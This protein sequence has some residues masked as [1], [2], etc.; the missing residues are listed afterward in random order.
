M[1]RIALGAAITAAALAT[2]VTSAAPQ[3]R[4]RD[5]ER[6]VTRS[7][8]G[9]AKLDDALRSRVDDGSTAQVYVFVTVSGSD[10]G[11]VRALLDDDAAAQRRGKA[12]VVGRISTQAV[13]KL[14]SLKNV[15]SVGLVQLTQT[16]KPLG[17]PDPLV[18]RQPS[19]ATGA[20][21]LKEL[22]AAE[23]PY[24]QAPAPK[25]SNFEQLRKLGVMDAKTH[26]FKDA[27]DAGYAGEG[28]TVGVLDGG[29]DFGHPDLLNTWQTWSGVTDTDFTDDGW[30]GWPKAFDPFG[31]LQ[32]LA[33]P[34]QVTGGLSW[35]TPTSAVTCP[36]GTGDCAVTFAT[37][38][39][40][41]RNFSAPNARATHTYTF[42]RAWSKSGRVRMGSH[43]D[44]YLLELYKERPAFLVT[45]P[46][47]AGVYDTV[48]VDLDH[49]NDFGDEKPVTKQSPA[50]YRDVNGDGY[51]DLS[52][53]LLYF[54]SDG[55]TRLP[56]GLAEFFGP[57]TPVFAPGAMLAWS[58]DYDPG[59]EGH[60]T[61]T[62]SNV[63]GQ[64][65]IN[66]GAPQFKDLPKDGRVPGAVLGGSPHA[67][68][69]P[70]GDIYFGF[71]FSTQFGYLLSTLHGID[72]TSNSYGSSDVDNDGYDAA[73]QEAD[74]IHDGS[75]TTPLF[76]TGNG[77][78]GFGTATSPQPSAG[79]AVG[80]STQFGATG[81]DSLAK[82]REAPDNDVISFS[83]RGP[84]ATGS[85][86]P[87]L[88]ADGAYSSG[89]ATLNTV[90]DGR[91]AW[92]TWGGT[93]RSTPVAVS[94]TALVYQAYKK[95]HGGSV[96]AGFYDTA[97]NILKSSA[98]DLHYDAFTQGAGSLDAGRAVRA[99]AG[100]DTTV[101]PDEW[102][103]G[104]YR[105]SED[106]VFTNVIA[107]GGSDTQKFTFSRPGTW[108]VT[109]RQLQRYDSDKFS[110]T[111]SSQTR[112]SAFSFNAPDYLLDLSHEVKRHDDADLMV[113]RAIFPHN[114]F[115]KDANYEA[116]QAWRM[117]AYNWTD[118]NHD[119]NLWTDRDRDGAVDHADSAATDIDGN[120]IPDF[121]RSEMDKGEYARFMYHRPGA[122][123]LTVS[124]RDPK[125]RMDDG[126]FLGLQHQIH[127]AGIDRTHFTIQ[128]DWYK[129]SDWSWVSHPTLANGSFS[130]T[131]NV[132]KNTPYGMY[133]GALVL[134][135]FGESTV[136]PISVAV[137]AQPAQDASG[138]L[139]GSAL[140][141]GGPAVANAQ[142]NLRYN[143]GSVFGATDWGWRAESGDWRFFFYDLAK[144]PPEGT[145]FLADTTWDD[146]APFTDLDTLVMGRSANTYQLFGGSDPFGG[147]YIID[148]VGTSENTNTGAGVWQFDTA[149]GGAREIVTA[150]AQEGLHSLVQHQV[151]WD[152][153]KFDVPFTTKLGSATVTPSAV[154]T[155]TTADSGSFDVTFKSS[156]DLDG[157]KAEGFGLS[158]PS[159]T[160]E[161]VAQDNPDDPATASNKKTIT[162]A[163]ASK[164][165]VKTEFPTEDIDL[166]VV[167]D[168]NNDGN[169]TASEIVASSAGGTANEEVELIRPADGKYQIWLHGF[170]VAG[171][172]SVKMTVN[173]IQGNDL[174][175]TGVPSDAVPAGTPVTLHVTYA[176]PMTVGQ[177]YFG[178]LLLGPA[179]APSAFTV[180]VTVRRR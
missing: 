57:D 136:V 122:N 176:K 108:L 27:W 37:R 103:V 134:K 38:V 51:T 126:L 61:L 163:H 31:T 118:T 55:Q 153:G 7:D 94:A 129:T 130:A 180:P 74:I 39:G 47:T 140:Q 158:Q 139:T 115:D 150:P 70:Y 85:T 66:G 3:Q 40:P 88:V 175:V 164:L 49:D 69:A 76:S 17:D 128:V 96:P 148:T 64:A 89:D 79:V 144:K 132:P 125:R 14:A 60:G 146:K 8:A 117:L 21:A 83:N 62:A 53:G 143:N 54:I 19:Q 113:V 86:G 112:E 48:Y 6:V 59:I 44:D 81:W 116:D 124:V 106:R 41:S 10:T 141:F 35:Y 93:S 11:N 32:W 147:P 45:D 155:T 22:A 101:A 177:D 169:F 65:V 87:D 80:A 30:N 167:Y 91:N 2:L 72:V 12:L 110:F 78:P 1:R 121:A 28:V 173:A 15:V 172:P 119:R 63:V 107:P 123:E 46:N 162:L 145:Q 43:P 36:A 151:G 131:V 5:P 71:D 50:S 104:D 166:F 135:R 99:A 97:R 84:G 75:F 137:A 179:T 133:D 24:S 154:D 156:V 174:T 34:T 20:S 92:G 178:E 68:L 100:K 127:N 42:P 160:Q 16:G 13:Q 170:A 56:G 77:A 4:G 171:N 165:Q 25:G 18:G 98:K 161:P 95:A 109:D 82:I 159:V 90:L 149:T 9:K 67:K 120:P 52:G 138:N 157:L 26:N 168:A 102:R 105:G 23:V 111:S 152:G 58:G 73:S 33:A 29:T 142:R 114:E